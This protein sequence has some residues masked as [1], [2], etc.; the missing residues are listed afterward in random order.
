[1]KTEQHTKIISQERRI[2]RNNT[3]VTSSLDRA[4]SRYTPESRESR[5]IS[6]IRKEQEVLNFIPEDFES[7]I[8]NIPGIGIDYVLNCARLERVANGLSEGQTNIAETYLVD[9]RTIAEQRR[10]EELGYTTY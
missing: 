10:D 1:M 7:D 6:F 5:L 3:N 2:E 9:Q 8:L 4:A